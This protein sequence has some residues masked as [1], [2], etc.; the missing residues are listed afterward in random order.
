M[1]ESKKVQSVFGAPLQYDTMPLPEGQILSPELI[2][3]LS[4]LP[5]E[6]E[7]LSEG[8]VTPWS[9]KKSDMEWEDRADPPEFNLSIYLIKE[10]EVGAAQEKLFGQAIPYLGFITFDLPTQ[11][12]LEDALEGTD[13]ELY[14]T[15]AAYQQAN[16]EDPI[17]PILY[18]HWISLR[19]V[20]EKRTK[21]LVDAMHQAQGT[22]VFAERVPYAQ[23]ATRDWPAMSFTAAL[24]STLTEVSEEDV[25]NYSNPEVAAQ[26]KQGSFLAN[27]LLATAVATGVVIVGKAVMQK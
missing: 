17:P 9:T 27:V 15:Q 11:K 25:R 2:H 16:T 10:K 1:Y 14:E 18:F 8:F 7:L 24:D 26:P 5:T 6:M 13:Y 4:Q 19:P 23:T 21:S 22:L 20:G 3:A 12:E